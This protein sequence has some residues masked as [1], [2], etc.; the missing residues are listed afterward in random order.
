[1]LQF[2]RQLELRTEDQSV[3]TYTEL[4]DLCQTRSAASAGRLD[5]AESLAKSKMLTACSGAANSRQGAEAVCRA[6]LDASVVMRLG[7]LIYL[8]PYDVAELVTQ[9]A[10]CLLG[11]TLITDPTGNLIKTRAGPA[12]HR[13]QGACNAPQCTGAADPSGPGE[14]PHG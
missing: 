12:G 3:L 7:H 10:A 13:G 5:T 8:R 9:V 11:Q 4:L 1:M 6:L 2:R 14:G